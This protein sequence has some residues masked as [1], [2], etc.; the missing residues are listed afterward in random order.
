V[1]SSVRAGS[2]PRR[3][4]P[5]RRSKG[6]MPSPVVFSL[7]LCY[8]HLAMYASNS[9]YDTIAAPAT[10]PGRGAIGIVRLSGPRALDIA[11]KI[12]RGRKDPA[13]MPGFTAA[14]GWVESGGR[15]L[16]EVLVLVMR[17][18][19]SYTGED[20]AEFHCHGGPLPLR[21]VLEAALK[22]GA[23]P[24]EPGEFT[25]RAFLA[26]KIDLARAEA[27]AD[28]IA[29][30]TE[31]AARAAAAQLEGNLSHRLGRLRSALVGLL[32]R[33]EAGI[34]FSD[35]ED[36][37]AVEQDE[38][39]NALSRLKTELSE[40]IDEAGRGRRLR[41]GARVVIC[42]RPNVG[43]STLMNRLLG[44]ERVIITP[45]PGTTRDLVEDMIEIK[46]VPIRL[47]DTAGLREAGEEAEAMGVDKA[48]KA[49]ASADLVLFMLDSSE[50]LQ[51]QDAAA[52][53][54]ISGPCII[55]LNKSDLPQAMDEADASG[56]LPEAEVITISALTGDGVDDLMSAMSALLA[57]DGTETPAV[58]NARHKLALEQALEAA[59]RA[60]AAQ[61]SGMS[62]EFI[63][64]D[65]RICLDRLGLVTGETATEEI[66][67][68]IF[69]RFCI[70][71]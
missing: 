71:K 49:V 5:S 27:V 31:R 21:L 50:P 13:Q 25:R 65:L 20:V 15:R 51:N 28:M 60:E 35:E 30:D 54:G 3:S 32:S 57:G 61:L 37:V 53:S 7:S 26:G 33:L 9:G 29:S 70:G 19:A 34:D 17:A 8:P 1:T 10:P 18:P 67:D 64:S 12:F 22:A 16:D 45:T 58:T 43:K 63:A 23:R 47:F 46:G 56:L 62:D 59:G 42:G 11:S 6:F 4:P 14:R 66:L 39:N 48:K 52:A 38:F 36:V 69:E 41:E 44:R 24:A 68:M 40:L 2:K 55:L